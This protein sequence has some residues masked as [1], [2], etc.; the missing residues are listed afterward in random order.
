MQIYV[1]YHL[2][3][4]D[5]VEFYNFKNA[6]CQASFHQITN[7]TRK[8]SEC[9][10]K[11]GNIDKQAG[12]WFKVFKG[13]CH[14]SFRKIRHTSKKEETKISLLLDKRRAY[15]QKLKMSEENEKDHIQSELLNLDEHVSELVAEKNRNKVVENIKILSKQDGNLNNNNMWNVKRKVFPK[16]KES[17]PFAKKIF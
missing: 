2:K 9:F 13:I 16:N 5:R 7:V 4:P 12:N 10:E 8:L 17:L 1:H 3:K 15:I 14:Q 6:E 11:A